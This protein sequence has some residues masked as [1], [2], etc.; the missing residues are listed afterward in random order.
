M[1]GAPRASSLGLDVRALRRIHDG[2]L[3]YMTYFGIRH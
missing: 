1:A 3:V 2:A